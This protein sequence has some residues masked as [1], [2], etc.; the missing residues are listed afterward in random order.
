M[1]SNEAM[2]APLAALARQMWLAITAE[3]TRQPA[4]CPAGRPAPARM[5]GDLRPRDDETGPRA[6]QIPWTA[7]HRPMPADPQ[8][9]RSPTGGGPRIASRLRRG[10]AVPQ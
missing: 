3:V 2:A 7:M 10:K 5:P 4:R 6:R 8:D 1:N 9:A